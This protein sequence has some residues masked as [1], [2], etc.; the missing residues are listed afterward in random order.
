MYKE[1]TTRFLYCQNIIVKI[2]F[3]LN[4][5]IDRTRTV[6]HTYTYIEGTFWLLNLSDLNNVHE[7]SNYYV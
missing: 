4:F 2:N 3:K 7:F 1:G 6:V 5:C